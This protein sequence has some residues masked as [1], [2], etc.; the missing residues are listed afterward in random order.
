MGKVTHCPTTFFYGFPDIKTCTR[1]CIFTLKED[2]FLIIARAN[3]F[4]TL[5]DLC[6]RPDVGVRVDCLASL[7]HIHRNHSFTVP[8]DSD[9]DLVR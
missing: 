1:S 7:H 6:Q 4:E 5:P 8:E 2:L 9:Y 3:P